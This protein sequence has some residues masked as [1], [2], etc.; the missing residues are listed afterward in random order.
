MDACYDEGVLAMNYLME[1]IVGFF[2]LICSVLGT[3]IV[4][5]FKGLNKTVADN[6]K[7]VKDS[8]I[9]IKDEMSKMNLKLE[10]VITDQSWHK[11]EMNEI[12]ETQRILFDRIAK[13][14][15]GEQ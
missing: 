4:M 8:I 1:I 10:K 11:E 3:M 13:I 9:E 5:Y 7:E 6:A 12:K 14:E 15:Q 2:G